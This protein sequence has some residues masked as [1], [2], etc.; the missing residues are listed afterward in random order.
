VN[1]RVFESVQLPC[2]DGLWR[3]RYPNGIDPN[4]TYAQTPVCTP[5]GGSYATSQTV[6]IT[7]LNPQ[8]SEL[9]YYTTDGSVPAVVGGVAQGTTQLYTA[10]LSITSNTTLSVIGVASGYVTTLPVNNVYQIVA[11]LAAPTFNPP[12]GSYPGPQSVIISGV[13]PALGP[14]GQPIPTVTIL[15]SIGNAPNPAAYFQQQPAASGINGALYVAGSSAPEP[16]NNVFGLV[17]LEAPPVSYVGTAWNAGNLTGFTPTVQNYTTQLGYANTSGNNPTTTA[18]MQG[19]TVGAYLQSV[20]FPGGS[21]DGSICIAAVVNIAAPIEGSPWAAGGSLNAQ[22][23]FQVP[24]ATTTT[25]APFASAN[26]VLT[27]SVDGTEIIL[28]AVL[29]NLGSTSTA[30]FSGLDSDGSISFG[31][32]LVAGNSQ[33]VS[34]AS[35]SAGYLTAPTT[36][37]YLSYNF[38]F[39]STQFAAILAYLASQALTEVF[40]TSAATP[41][42]GQTLTFAAKPDNAATGWGVAGSHIQAGTT[43]TGITGG[44]VSLSLVTTGVVAIGAAITFTKPNPFTGTNLTLTNWNITG[45]QVRPVIRALAGDACTLGWSMQNALVFGGPTVE[46]SAPVAVNVSEQLNAIALYPGVNN[47]GV[48]SAVYTI[49]AAAAAITTTSPLPSGNQNVSYAPT[50]DGLATV[51][52]TAPVAWALASGSAITPTTWL[53]LPSYPNINNITYINAAAGGAPADGQQSVAPANVPAGA[54]YLISE[55]ANPATANGFFLYN[56][57]D[58][59]SHTGFT[60]TGTNEQ[61]S[62]AGTGTSPSS[63]LQ[64]SAAQMGAL[65]LGS[66]NLSVAP[67]RPQFT[68]QQN[69]TNTPGSGQVLWTDS[70]VTMTETLLLQVATFVGSATPDTND[71]APYIHVNL[72]LCPPGAAFEFDINV[73]ILDGSGSNSD[74]HHSTVSQTLPAYVFF[75]PIGAGGNIYANFTAGTWQNGT[76]GPTTFTW[77]ISY[78]QMEAIINYM[79]TTGGYAA[80]FAPGGVNLRPEQLTLNQA[81][82]NAEMPPSISTIQLGWNVQNW[83]ITSTA[84][85][86]ALPT[87]MS[88]PSAGGTASWGTPTVAYGPTTIKV[89]ATDSANPPNVITK[90]LSLTIAAATGGTLAPPP[91][92]WATSVGQTPSNLGSTSMQGYGGALPGPVFGLGWPNVSGNTGYA[93]FVSTTSKTGPWTQIGTVAQN[94][95]TYVDQPATG[96]A[97]AVNCV[98][99]YPDGTNDGIYQTNSAGLYFPG[100]P[101]WYAVATINANGTGA[102]SGTQKQYIVY[103]GSAVGGTINPSIHASQSGGNGCFKWWGEFNDTNASNWLVK[104]YN[105]SAGSE[106]GNCIALQGTNGG[107]AFPYW[108]CVAGWICPVFGTCVAAADYL[109]LDLYIA[110][111]AGLRLKIWGEITGDTQT[112]PGSDNP[113][114]QFVN[115]GAGGAIQEGIY[116]TYRIPKSYFMTGNGQASGN[117]HSCPNGILQTEAYKFGINIA[118]GSANG[119]LLDNVY[120]GT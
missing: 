96:Y 72:G 57:W 93:I 52:T 82:I 60:A 38:S 113:I 40:D 59:T 43:I 77:S 111:G 14:A 104:S 10:P 44:V 103:G 108:L 118:S 18:Q 105:N 88:I 6:A 73:C 8:P 85:S 114:A 11:S 92:L 115:N 16:P 41:N 47:S 56:T 35:G 28:Q 120:W 106:T 7:P 50:G 75:L 78:A 26:A 84:G 110:P 31:V 25:A 2:I 91:N 27:S 62:V 1:N 98:N 29:L 12:A 39:S 51:N 4:L 5:P 3:P 30:V 117:G 9:F 36:G 97:G 63:T 79:A 80:Q 101:R 87:G 37:G 58:A 71:T 54:V 24:T 34:M 61:V 83:S 81:H 95:T 102:L 107:S 53:T 33:Y 68:P 48:A 70:T 94:V 17:A 15:Y 55:N 66:D 112:A 22:F 100:S 64:W 21:S 86:A 42:A 67:K 119:C 46:Y 90:N 65:M 109:Y 19:N 74:V 69:F 76:F 89:Q 49:T 45:F 99:P 20:D 32:P 13:V 23:G 116:Q